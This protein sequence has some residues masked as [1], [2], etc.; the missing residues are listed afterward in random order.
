MLKN[1]ETDKLIIRFIRNLT[2]LA[3]NSP[4]LFGWSRNAFSFF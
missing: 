3:L 1:F 4:A 2:E